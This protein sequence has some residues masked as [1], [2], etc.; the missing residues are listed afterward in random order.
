MSLTLPAPRAVPFAMI[1]MPTSHPLILPFC[2]PPIALRCC[3]LAVERGS[4]ITKGLVVI[5]KVILKWALQYQ[6]ALM[7]FP[8]IVRKQSLLRAFI[9]QAA[10]KKGGEEDRGKANFVLLGSGYHI[11]PRGKGVGK[12]ELH[13]LLLG[14]CG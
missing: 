6:P 14:M 13:S 7:L 5:R 10:S 12:D 8:C 1:C 2:K 11:V 9:S 3:P 4:L